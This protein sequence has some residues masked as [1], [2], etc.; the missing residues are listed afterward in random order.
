MMKRNIAFTLAEVM[1]TMGIIGVVAALTIPSLVNTYQKKVYE[2]SVKK[3]HSELEQGFTRYLADHNTTKLSY[4]PFVNSDGGKAEFYRNYFRLATRCASHS[5]CFGDQYAD[6]N[7]QVKTFDEA[8]G[9]TD[10][11]ILKSGASICIN[12]ENGW[13]QTYTDSDGKTHGNSF[14][15]FDT[16]GK[17]PPNV[18]GRDFFLAYIFDDGTVDENAATPECKKSPSVQNCRGY[19]S[20]KAARVTGNCPGSVWPSGCLGALLD[21]NWTMDY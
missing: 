10:T 2:A 19:A 13:Y 8:S 16:N 5:E 15:Y 1:I 3:F 12:A 9:C 20:L 18:T 11:F 4:T 21:N 17:N 7:G 14:I 6:I